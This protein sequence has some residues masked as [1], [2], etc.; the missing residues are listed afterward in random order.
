MSYITARP[1][2]IEIR[3]NWFQ[4]MMYLALAA[5]C[6]A[7]SWYVANDTEL[8]SGDFV[9]WIA[10]LGVVFCAA[11]FLTVIWNLLHA[12]EVMIRVS[13][14]GVWIK[15]GKNGTTFPWELVDDVVRPTGKNKQFLVLQMTDENYRK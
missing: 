15:G 4:L 8:T 5:F 10:W 1:K 6:G 3:S 9:Y 13:A 12:G 2:Q 11:I 14:D 7:I